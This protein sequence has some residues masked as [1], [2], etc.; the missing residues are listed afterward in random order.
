MNFK[1]KP[2]GAVSVR[3]R[4]NP[5]THH[6]TVRVREMNIAGNEGQLATYRFEWHGI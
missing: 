2:Y 5:S 3:E 1:W 4:M 6:N